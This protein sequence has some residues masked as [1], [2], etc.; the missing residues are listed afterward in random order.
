MAN[1]QN[2]SSVFYS[3]INITILHSSPSTHYPLPLSSLCRWWPPSPPLLPVPPPP[4]TWIAWSIFSCLCCAW[5]CGLVAIMYSMKVNCCMVGCILVLQVYM[6]DLPCHTACHLWTRVNESTW[7]VNFEL[8]LTQR[9]SRNEA[10]MYLGDERN[11][12]KNILF[13]WS[14]IL[15]VLSKI[16]SISH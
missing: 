13:P 11:Q 4:T 9:C 5:P 6:S 15:S 7:L 1:R 8:G 12:R 2:C 14:P 10:R 3:L 16:S